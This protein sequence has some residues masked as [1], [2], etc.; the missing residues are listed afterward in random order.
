MTP[1]DLQ[2][3]LIEQAPAIPGIAA[4]AEREDDSPYGL[5][6]T[7]AHGGRVWWTIAGALGSPAADPAGKDPAAKDLPEQWSLP[8]L[9]GRPVPVAHVEQALLATATTADVPGGVC[10]IDRYS[11]RPN[12]PAVRY[13][14]NLEC[15]DGWKLFLS[16]YGTA[17]DGRTTPEEP[18]Q[19]HSHV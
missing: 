12:P 10:R 3:L 14:G 9:T 7:L 16:C 1:A 17:R 13:G 4:V 5:T 11:T 2:Q 6:V 19:P 8:D 15:R 18:Y